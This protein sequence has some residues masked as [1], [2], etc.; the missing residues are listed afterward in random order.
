MRVG[1]NALAWIG[2]TNIESQPVRDVD[3]T[4]DAPRDDHVLREDLALAGV[5]PERPTV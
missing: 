3:V 4:R 5:A 2:S 1:A